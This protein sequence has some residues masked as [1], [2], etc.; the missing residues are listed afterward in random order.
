MSV[1]P[2]PQVAGLLLPPDALA[3]VDAFRRIDRFRGDY[4]SRHL[5]AVSRRMRG[6]MP[7]AIADAVISEA[8]LVDGEIRLRSKGRFVCFNEGAPT[9]SADE[10][11]L[12]NLIAAMQNAD[13]TAAAEAAIQ[14][15]ILQARSL[16]SLVFRLGRC[17]A[18]GGIRFRPRIFRG[19][20]VT[21]R[22]SEP[23]PPRGAPLLKL[24]EGC[25]G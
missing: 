4:E 3:V 17:L 7:F 10:A 13:Y 24:V 6:L 22:V 25:G 19:T 1:H 8:L 2:L 11:A 23:R 18:D 21:A 5:D 15:E 12:L 9:A 14:L 20:A 16:F